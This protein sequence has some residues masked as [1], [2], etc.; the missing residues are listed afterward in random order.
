MNNQWNCS[1][2]GHANSPN[3]R[4]CS[5]CGYVPGV[6]NSR[7]STAFFNLEDEDIY[8]SDDETN[9]EH[10]PLLEAEDRGNNPDQGANPPRE[11]TD[12]QL[13]LLQSQI[14]RIMELY[15]REHT[16]QN[17]EGP[18]QDANQ[19]SQ[20]HR[21]IA[22]PLSRLVS[23]CR[24]FLLSLRLVNEGFFLLLENVPFVALLVIMAISYRFKCTCSV[25][26]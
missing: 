3:N 25:G 10:V 6:D 4:Q 5:Y 12:E 22:I 15:E 1:I 18:Q 19:N 16:N 8:I 24:V 20:R 26:D 7:Q 14:L 13:R 11:M 23:P 9:L 2:C 21:V 17:S